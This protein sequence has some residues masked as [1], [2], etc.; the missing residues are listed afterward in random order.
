MA[1]PVPGGHLCHVCGVLEP[2]PDHMLHEQG[3]YAPT[4]LGK[5]RKGLRGHISR[6]EVWW[7]R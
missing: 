4:L 2:W 3:E 1:C 5:R 7:V 6:S